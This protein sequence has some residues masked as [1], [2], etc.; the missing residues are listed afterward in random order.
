MSQE[1]I[2]KKLDAFIKDRNSSYREVSHAIGKADQYIQQYIRYGL[3]ARLKAEDRQA[4]ARYLDI[5]EQELS[6]TPIYKPMLKKLPDVINID[7]L[8]V[9][10]CCGGGLENELE[11]IIGTWQMPLVDYNAMSLSSP[12]NIKIIKAVGDSMI[13]TIADGDYVFVD[14]SN[15]IIGSD[16]VYVLRLPT[17]LSIKRIQNGLTG[18]VIVRSDNPAYEPLTAKLGDVRILGRV[19]R[20]MNMRKI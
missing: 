5:D 16:G 20:V 7:M 9:S 3:P 15:P 18:D 11:P 8:D 10:A 14:I 2:R 4:I 12:E 17:G 13:P 19:V 1:E 6:D